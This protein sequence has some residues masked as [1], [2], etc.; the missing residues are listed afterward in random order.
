MNIYMI[1]YLERGTRRILNNFQIV[2]NYGKAT[3]YR[4]R[5]F[6]RQVG[7]KNV[8]FS[9]SR[10]EKRPFSADGGQQVGSKKRPFSAEICSGGFARTLSSSSNSEAFSYT[11]AIGKFLADLPSRVTC[12]ECKTG[13]D[14]R[15]SSGNESVAQALPGRS[16][17][18]TCELQPR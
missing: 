10:I 13:T 11:S 15:W 7:S 1:F 3:G 5:P 14:R 16:A 18:P 9:V 12:N 8:P 2:I 4:K 17:N 6:F